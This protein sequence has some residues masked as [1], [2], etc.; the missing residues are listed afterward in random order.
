MPNNT[1]IKINNV[2]YRASSNITIFD[3][4]SL[5]LTGPALYFLTGENGT[6][7]STLA[8]ILAGVITAHEALHGTITIHTQSYDLSHATTTQFLHA[9]VAYIPPQMHTMVAPHFTARENLAIA[10]LPRYPGFSLFTPE[11]T[12]PFSIPLDIPAQ[13]LSSGQTQL[14]VIAMVLQHNPSVLI[15]DEP[16]SA[17]DATHTAQVMDCITKI[18]KQILCMCICHD[19]PLIQQYSNGENIIRLPL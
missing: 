13:E 2:T 11:D 10:A 16:T 17:L 6:G 1:I 19:E 8:K 5:A 14:L 15:L 18:S 4:V 3:N 9:Q 12:L 7:K